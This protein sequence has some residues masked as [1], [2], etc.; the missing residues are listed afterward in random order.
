MF[1]Q[2]VGN[3]ANIFVAIVAVLVGFAVGMGYTDYV[4]T[5]A[6]EQKKD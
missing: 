5:K 3:G 1:E 6:K 2:F 4:R